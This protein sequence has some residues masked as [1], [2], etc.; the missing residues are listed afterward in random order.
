MIPEIL[1]T[2][3]CILLILNYSKDIHYVSITKNTHTQKDSQLMR[4]NFEIIFILKLLSFSL[5]SQNVKN[6]KGEV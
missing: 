2:S 1:E 5:L 3:S 4:K 6:V